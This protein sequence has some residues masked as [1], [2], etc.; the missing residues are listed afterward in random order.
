MDP[1]AK[2]FKISITL[3]GGV[4]LVLCVFIF[5]QEVFK[6]RPAAVF[7]VMAPP[8]GLIAG[9]PASNPHVAEA[10]INPIPKGP[11][12]PSPAPTV[13][14]PKKQTPP[15]AM[16]SDDFL[17]A[18]PPKPKAVKKKSDKGVLKPTPL[19]KAEKLSYS[20]FQKKYAP[21][22]S[23]KTSAKPK[24]V[25]PPPTPQAIPSGGPSFEEN[26]ASRLDKRLQ[27]QGEA[28]V[29][30][31]LG[32]ASGSG[33]MGN[34]TP[35]AIDDPDAIYSGTIYTYL[36]SVWEEPK[37]V[38][39]VHLFARAEFTVDREGTITAWR[40]TRPS[41]VEAFDRSVSRVFSKVKSV[42]PPPTPQEYRLSVTFET[43]DS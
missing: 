33:V 9:G 2:G 18:A 11:K 21:K 35:G 4:I 19:K 30:T 10:S 26:L 14:T 25:K 6:P 5:F 17:D 12:L 8:A 16:P 20:E 28:T 29:G 7:T 1:Y 37:E 34:G 38:G 27:E 15:A 43:R 36:N 13:E 24:K 39:S 40:I 23:P 31:G 22:T 32:G 42:S 41:G 3:H